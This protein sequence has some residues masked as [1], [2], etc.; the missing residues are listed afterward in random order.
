M[1]VLLLGGT[2]ETKEFLLLAKKV[3]LEVILSTLTDWNLNLPFSVK[4]ISGPL[5]ERSLKELILKEHIDVIVDLT[6]P[7]ACEISR[8]AYLVSKE[9][10]LPLF[11]YI[12]PT[13]NYTQLS[14][15]EVND[16]TQAVK[17]ILEYKKNTLLTIGIKNL[18][19]YLDLVRND[20][21]DF[22][23]KILPQSKEKALSLGFLEEKLLSLPACLKE[24]EWEKIFNKHKIKI[25]VSKE[26][27]KTYSFT[28]KIKACQQKHIH[29]ILIKRPPKKIGRPFNSLSRLVQDIKK[30]A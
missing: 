5:K 30:M 25:V 14:Y 11:S 16:H 6:H 13:L 3:E 27:G 9:L 4:R 8:L 18:S 20:F 12:R 21:F 10:S 28:Q 17:K 1:K 7:F 24:E 26:A 2:E 15:T 19:L 23:V 29:L 22:W